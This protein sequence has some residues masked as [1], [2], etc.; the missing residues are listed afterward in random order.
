MNLARPDH[1]QTLLLDADDTLWE[2]NRYFEEAIAGFIS[3]LDGRRHS[4]GEIRA[5]LNRVEQ[6]TIRRRGYGTESFRHSLLRCF[7]ELT[8]SRPTAA[9]HRQVTGFVDAVVNAEIELLPG[10][11]AAL[12]ALTTRHRLILVTKGDD[13]EQRQKLERSG[14]GPFFAIVEVLKEKHDAAYREVAAK[15]ACTARSTWMIGNSPKSDINP[16]LLAGLHAVYIPHPSTWMLEREQ[17][18][19]PPPGQLLLQVDALRELAEWM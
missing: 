15:H 8:E 18:I 4:P 19:Q 13:L 7:E 2:N 14:L 1:G 10:V 3:L 9:Q 12:E 16:A 17:V 6:Q 5:H 11:H